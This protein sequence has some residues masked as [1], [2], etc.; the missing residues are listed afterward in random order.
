MLNNIWFG[1]T[2]IYPNVSTELAAVE[3]VGAEPPGFLK[4]ALSV[5]VLL[6][7]ASCLKT[8]NPVCPTCPVT[9]CPSVILAFRLIIKL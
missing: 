6:P 3:S 5:N 4:A 1:A 8:I 9:G 2:I 7:V